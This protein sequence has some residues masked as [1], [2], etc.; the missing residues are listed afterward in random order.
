MEPVARGLTAPSDMAL[1]PDGRIFFLE[2]TTGNVRVIQ[3]GHLVSAPFATVGVAATGEEGLLGVTVHP[4]FS[5][6]GWVY[7]YYTQA[8][9]YTN[10]IVRYTAQGNTGVLPVT[11]LDDIGTAT[12]NGEDN[13]GSLVFGSD[14]KLYAGV[15]VMEQDSEAS[16]TAS[17][18]GKILRIND[19]G[20]AP[21]DN[22]YY[23]SLSYPYNLIYSLGYRNTSDLAVHAGAGTMY[24]S[25]N[26]DGDS[27]CDEVN[28]ASFNSD[29]GWSTYSCGSETGGA[30]LPV[31]AIDP[32]ITTMGVASYT[33][34]SYPGATNNLFV[35]GNGNGKI[36]KDVLTGAGYDTLDSSSEW[37]VPSG[38]NCPVGLTDLDAGS[39]GW[40]YV[41]A[42][43]PTAGN[44]G[45][46]R[47]IHDPIGGSDAGPR[48][49]SSSDYTPMTL[50]K[51]PG[52][53]L[54]IY[55]AD[56]K[57]GAWGCSPGH[58]PTGARAD[59]YTVWKGSLSSLPTYDHTALVETDG[60][61]ESDALLSY[62]EPTMP[63]GDH[64]YLISARAD[65]LE[66]SLGQQT[67][68]SPGERPGHTTTDICDDIG[69]GIRTL[70]EDL[71]VDTSTLGT[72]PDQ[73]NNL[74]TLDDFRGKAIVF[75][76]VQFG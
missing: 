6:N 41:L 42:D 3:D 15:G 16:S 1:A 35:A 2:R 7:I 37:Y 70:D 43:D 17:L 9:P 59:K 32:Q 22:P 54:K 75:V 74:W 47:V 40:L 14:G 33:G 71:C 26:Y 8:S 45:I 12:T 5:D 25:D 63:A 49:V 10:R 65:H 39:D 67:G 64:Y 46:Y 21:T 34:S 56:L 31:H 73:D 50:D 52:G 29:H 60:T 69:Y 68:A 4:D 20:T 18:R 62:I 11:I 24:V 72:Y 58:C 53:G 48:E 55:W 61:A 38:V 23:G 51:D 19:D 44:K 27:T 66:G 76:F 57:R 36:M 28:V 30:E 13:G